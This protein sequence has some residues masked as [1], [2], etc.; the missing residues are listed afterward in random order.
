MEQR[1]FEDRELVLGEVGVLLAG[2]RVRRPGLID[3][4][5]HPDPSTLFVCLQALHEGVEQSLELSLRDAD[6]LAELESMN[7]ETGCMLGIAI[8]DQQLELACG[9][10]GETYV[11]DERIGPAG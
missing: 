7:G 5:L 3:V 2:A 6:T 8:R 11:H 9:I 1:S 4:L 10:L